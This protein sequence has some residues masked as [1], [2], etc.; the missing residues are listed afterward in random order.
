MD[1]AGYDRFVTVTNA[2]QDL[3]QGVARLRHRLAVVGRLEWVWSAEA[4]TETGMV[5]VHALVRSPYLPQAFL[6]RQARAAG[7]GAVADVRAG[8][9]NAGGYASKAA[10]YAAKE[11]SR[12]QPWVALNGGRRPWH[13]S[14]LYTA[15]VP[16]RDWVRLHAPTRDPG[17][18]IMRTQYYVPPV[19]REQW[20]LAW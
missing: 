3:L 12:Y 9:E 1:A 13:W 14:R 7:F 4:G 19:V 6:S 17:P 16:M 20:E 10:S 2:P 8:G 18:F 15:G 5:H 11:L